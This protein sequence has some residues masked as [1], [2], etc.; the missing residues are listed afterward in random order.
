MT[1]P[2]VPHCAVAGPASRAGRQ[3][4]PNGATIPAA[5]TTLTRPVV[6]TTT[7]RAAT[8][9]I[10]EDARSSTLSQRGDERTTSRLGGPTSTYLRLVCRGEVLRV[11]RRD[12]L[13][14]RQSQHRQRH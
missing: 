10:R 7:T 5:A 14:P 3:T 9:A 11:P 8:T 4:R 6:R 12:Q 2:D 13:I 1:Q